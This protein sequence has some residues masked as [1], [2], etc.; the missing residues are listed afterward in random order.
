MVLNCCN[1]EWFKIFKLRTISKMMNLSV[2]VKSARIYTY[3]L[4][5]SRVITQP[6]N[7]SNFHVFYL[8]MD[9]L[10]A[11]EKYTLYLSNL[12]AHR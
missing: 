1:G 8:M 10:S 9:G 12:S 6:L 7:Q 5:K 2:C 3:M 11:E 4:E